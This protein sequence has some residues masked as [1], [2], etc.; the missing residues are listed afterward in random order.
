MVIIMFERKILDQVESSPLFGVKI[1]IS[2]TNV[3]YVSEPERLYEMLTSTVDKIIYIYSGGISIGPIYH[4]QTSFA[5]VQLAVKYPFEDLHAIQCTL[6]LQ[7][8]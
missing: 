6:S 2:R 8:Y 1:M 4:A 5:S 7:S 3:F